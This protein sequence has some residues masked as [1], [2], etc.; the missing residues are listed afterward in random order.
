MNLT[1]LAIYRP[2][3]IIVLFTVL[4]VLGLFSYRQLSYELLPNLNTPFVTI[5]TT[6]PGAAPAEVEQSVTKP[7]EDV[8]STVEKIKRVTSFSSDSYSMVTLEFRMT[9]NADQAAQEVQRKVNEIVGTL[10]T[11]V[12]TPMV[13]KYDIGQLPVIR[14][15]VTAAGLSGRQ[16]REL[17]TRQVRPR[18]AQLPGVGQVAIIGGDE[19]EIR[20]SLR[21]DALRLYNL[22]ALQV[23]QTIKSA[24]LDVPAGSVQNGQNEVS[25]RVMGR[26]VSLDALRNQVITRT[27]S[28]SEVRLRQVAD[29]Q[30]ATRDAQTIGR[31]NGVASVGLNIQKQTDANA[32]EVAR[33]VRAELTAL[34]TEF[35][36][37]KFKATIASDS[38]EF[39]LDAA[40]AVNHDL[41]LAVCLVAVVTLVFLHSLRNALIVMVAIPASL[42]ST[43]IA[44]YAFGFSLNLMTLLAMSLVIGILVDDSIVVLENIYKHLEAGKE[45]KRAA[46]DGR[47]E[48]G[49]TALSITLVDVVVFLPISV[50]PGLVGNL[51]REFSL[52][53]VVST[54]LSL[55]VSFTVTPMLASRFSKLE[56]LSTGTLMGRFGLWFERGF[57]RLTNGYET[58]LRW[59]LAHRKTVFLTSTTLFVGSLYLV[60]GGYVGS[61][62]VAATD[63]GQLSVV[64][65]LPQGTR[66]QT[67]DAVAKRLEAQL[68]ARPDV[69]RVF[70]SVGATS[71][72][73]GTGESLP[74]TVEFSVTLVNK[75]QRTQ[76]SAAVGRAIKQQL[77]RESRTTGV[78]K[79]RVGTIGLFGTVDDSPI[80]VVMTS[81]NRDTLLSVARR[82]LTLVK[83]VPGTD[84]VRLSTSEPKLETRVAL[85]HDKLSQFGLTTDNV[86]YG[87]R[88]AFN[89]DDESK[90]RIGDSDYRINIR[91]DS[92]SRAQSDRLDR[93]PFVNDRG[94]AV[95]LQQI[96][97]VETAQSPAKLERRARNNAIVLY[98]Q[99]NNRPSGDVGADI[100]AAV[101]K[102]GL[103]KQ[104]RIS[105]EGD[106]ELANDGFDALGLALGAAILFVYLIMVAL[107]NSW[108][109]PLVVLFSIPVAIVGALAAL[110][111][112]GNAL[113]I[114]SMLGIIMLIGLVTKNA[115]LLVDR[116]NQNRDNG[117]G[118]VTE[119]LIESGRSRLRP[120]LMTTLAMVIGML[121][122]ALASGAGAEWKTGLAWV[123]IGGLSSSLFLT[124]L[125]VPAVYYDVARLVAWF[126]RKTGPTIGKTV[127]AGAVLMGLC[128]SGFAI[129]TSDTLRL[130]LDDAI[131]LGLAQNASVKV[132]QLEE[133]RAQQRVREARGF[134]LPEVSAGL[135]YNRFLQVPK[136]LFPSFVADPD[137][138]VRVDEGRFQVIDAG[139]RNAWNLTGQVSVPIINGGVRNGIR[140]AEAGVRVAEAQT[141]QARQ[142]LVAEIRKAYYQVLIAEEARD[143]ARQAIRRAEVSLAET[144]QLARL[145]MAT[146][147]DTLQAFVQTEN[148]R[149]DVEKAA[150]GLRTAQ[151]L[152]TYL[153]GAEYNTPVHLTD[154]LTPNL[155]S[156]PDL[157][158][159]YAEALARRPDLGTLAAQV[160]AS[161]LQI[162][163]AVQATRPTLAFSGQYTLSPQANDFNFSRYFW[164]QQ[165]FVGLTL[166]VPIYAGGRHDARIQQARIAQQQAEAQQAQVRRQVATEVQ[167]ALAQVQDA[168]RR[169]DS[170]V[171]TVGAAE[172]SYALI[173][174]RYQKGLAKR[175]DLAE[176]DFAL[177]QAQTNR[178][179]AVYDYLV[180][181]SELERVTGQ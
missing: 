36:A 141:A 132:A 78:R 104:V 3:L 100:Q 18:L 139:L 54:L 94:Q 162:E 73:G 45:P 57:E 123:L 124:L 156:V 58:A 47:T 150:S 178:V 121:P 60:V 114:F 106:L 161:R 158:T 148:H 88:V 72:G 129:P 19:R 111:L 164:P 51:L 46:E 74:N 29:V 10:P 96:G 136:F 140:Q 173:N 56:H 69:Q 82:M 6:Y 71:E 85:D 24:N 134:R 98:S 92:V 28:G 39:T 16:F 70:T 64:V 117:T 126:A 101:A 62:F 177:R 172:R 143:I 81:T 181:V 180:A 32:V 169:I 118:S 103:D 105:Y 153:I 112:T 50:V 55:L 8:V 137:V 107:Y 80:V 17:L 90:F 26:Y 37:E 48:I 99:L 160:A 87:L 53:M 165:S 127:V 15:G 119:A 159:A 152:L 42:V 1:R 97:R 135:S 52:V 149:P 23:A 130:S 142:T 4:G 27:G 155:N 9:A 91:F 75:E 144:R 49:F 179:Q 61:E 131:R 12:K 128:S 86:G 14:A 146:D 95:Q 33:L 110:W 30:E 133:L 145:G 31:L 89:G 2:I 157:S 176:A 21:P 102:A 65:E 43:F 5:A 116:A 125:L 168:R 174:S 41:L 175:T 35:S 13:L 115:I 138:G 79:V 108:A 83:N 151:T 84:N 76:T 171:R 25:L 63:R 170:Q 93:L 22:T 38:S 154:R 122:I 66:L 120:I 34:E 67:T 59:A 68:R 44:M 40:D 109:Y 166:S 163:A 7:L 167:S 147:A 20:L 77:L 11:G 113:S